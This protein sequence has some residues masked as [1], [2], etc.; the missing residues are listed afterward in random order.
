MAGIKEAKQ[1]IME[2]VDFFNDPERF[3]QLGA[4]I[5]R[6]ILLSGSPGAGKTLLARALA[7]EA[8][9]PFISLSSSS[10]IDSVQGV[11]ALR[12]RKI[13]SRAKELAPCI[14]F[15]DEIDSIGRARS[16]VGGASN[17]DREQTINQ[18]LTEMDG[19]EGNSGVIVLAATN[20]PGIL[21]PALT[22]PGRFDRHIS[23]DLP[24]LEGRIQILNLYSLDKA[25]HWSVDLT[26]VA[27]RCSGMSGADLGNVMNE[28][29]ILSARLG[30][31]LITEEIIYEVIEKIQLG[32]KTA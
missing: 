5:P 25:M 21:D 23:V 15:I 28:A 18:L 17:S 27:E 12:I 11:G 29:A 13:F 32:L 1:E 3:T 2:I 9:V 24:D 31:K 26:K 10:L 22:R 8:N 7:G 6:G 20:L 4:R 30:K 14:L 19:F 16:S